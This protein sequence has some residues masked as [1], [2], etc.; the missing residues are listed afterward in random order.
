MARTGSLSLTSR[1]GFTDVWI[2]QV[3]VC[4]IPQLAF[5]YRRTVN[6]PTVLSVLS[7][8]PV[9]RLTLIPETECKQRKEEIYIHTYLTSSAD[10]KISKDY[11]WGVFFW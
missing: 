5:A 4:I 9:V 2:R 8:V 11:Y 3:A 1:L 7:V 6:L 10:S